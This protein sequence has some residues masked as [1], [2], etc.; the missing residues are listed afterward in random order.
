MEA[1]ARDLQ[2]RKMLCKVPEITLYFW[3]IKILATTV[4]ETAADFLNFNLGF[5][6]TGTSAVMGVLLIGVLV[7][8]LASRRYIPWLYWLTVV[9][10]SI[11]GTLITDNLS[12]NLGVPLWISTLGFSVVLAITFRIWYSSERTLSIHSI[13]TTRRELFYWAAILFTF[14]LGTAGGDL[15]TEGIGLGYLEGIVIFGGLIALTTFGYYAR[16]LTSVFAFWVAYILTRPL[17]ASIGDLL[18]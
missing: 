17:G 2:G 18:M 10:I 1:T 11:V 4:G 3:I 9:L 13:F 14:A 16:G 15:A 6:L 5:G 12:D 8:Q 7:L